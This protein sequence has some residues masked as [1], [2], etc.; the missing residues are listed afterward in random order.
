M[1][2]PRGRALVQRHRDASR[3]PPTSTTPRGLCPLDRLLVETDSPY[4]APVPHRGKRNQPAWV[5]VVGSAVADLK[6][7]SAE[8]VAAATWSTAARTYRLEA[9]G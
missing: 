1:P 5:P 9:A 3:R 8:E 2:R 4:L 7:V 6:G